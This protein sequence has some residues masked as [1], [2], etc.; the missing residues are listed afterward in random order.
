MITCK[1]NKIIFFLTMLYYSGSY[2]SE[3]IQNGQIILVI[4]L[5]VMGIYSFIEA[6]GKFVIQIGWF[7]KYILIFLV[8]CVASM[9]W[10]QDP[11]LI[12]PKRDALLFI[13]VAMIVIQYCHLYDTDIDDCIK[14][15]MYGGY[16]FI[17]YIFL[18]YGISGVINL[19]SDNMRISSELLNSNAIG[20]CAAYSIVINLYYIVY[21]KM[22]LR[23]VLMIPALIITI[24]SRSRK[25]IILIALGAIG[26]YILKNLKKKGF[27][28]FLLKVLGGI[29]ASILFI[30]AISRLPFMQPIIGRLE[31]VWEMILGDGTRSN[32]SAWIRFAYTNLGVEIFKEN[33]ITGIGIGNANIYTQAAYGHNHY[34]HNNFVEL[35]ACGGIVG[36]L[37]HYSMHLYLVRNLIK[38]WNYRDREY[39]IC[40]ILLIAV[41][42]MDFGV[43]SYYSRTHYLVLFSI[44]KKIKCLQ[45]MET[46]INTYTYDDFET[47]I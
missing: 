16:F 17:I 26:V 35:L 30:L 25:A 44:W 14:A 40:L 32:N 6:K 4:I 22:T 19:V 47:V 41:L 11:E 27:G 20:M 24:V 43:V 37:L 42:V 21:K 39:D 33:P 2:I 29:V 28:V 23:D 12:I 13:L 9:L 5:G 3:T 18:R 38:Y 8:F 1:K 36:F 15:I 45:K 31:D 10:A 7:V 34:L 46:G